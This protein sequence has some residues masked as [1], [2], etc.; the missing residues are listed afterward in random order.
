MTEKPKYKYEDIDEEDI[1]KLLFDDCNIFNVV[2]MINKRIK[3]DELKV[4]L[5]KDNN[6]V[7]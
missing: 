3:D 5:R 6:Y 2:E 4:K 1:E 7:K